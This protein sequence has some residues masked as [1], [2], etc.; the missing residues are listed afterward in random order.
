MRNKHGHLNHHE[1][2]MHRYLYCYHERKNVIMFDFVKPTVYNYY[3]YIS[4]LKFDF[5]QTILLN[6]KT[7][8][9]KLL[10]KKIGNPIFFL[11]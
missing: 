7:T 8:T 11:A 10:E 1:S 3:Q 2:F 4:R 5:G 6:A 9:N